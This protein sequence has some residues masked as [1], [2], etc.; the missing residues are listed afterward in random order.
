M[1]STWV[2]SQT[3]RPL[4]RRVA[5]EDPTVRAVDDDGLGEGEHH[6]AVAGLGLGQRPGDGAGPLA[7]PDGCDQ[8]P[9]QQ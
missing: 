5:L 7:L 6:A 2:T 8:G 3:Q 4:G 1:F 9:G